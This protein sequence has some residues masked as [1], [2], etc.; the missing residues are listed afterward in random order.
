M[1][2]E[3]ELRQPDLINYIPKQAMVIYSTN[4]RQGSSE[5][6]KYYIEISDIMMDAQRSFL[7]AGK[8]VT[9]QSLQMLMDVVAETDKQTFHSVSDITP[10]NLLVIDQRA[11]RHILAWWRPAQRKTIMMQKRA[12]HTLWVPPMVFI[13]KNQGLSVAAMNK[14]K[15][16]GITTRL[17]H[18]PFF[19]VYNDMKVCLGTVKPP[20]TDGD[21]H[22]LIAEWEKAFWNS[23][24]TE[25]VSGAY[26]KTDLA[27]WWRKKR[28][29]RF[30]LKKLKISTINLRQLCQGN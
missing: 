28:R 5:N 11:G 4:P 30:N 27:S 21:I 8:P 18:A 2:I 15:R 10:A 25:T 17:H 7:S 19:N 24:F 26:K 23:E 20:N 6:V 3:N 12:S 16:P 22:Q 14:S 9:K 1:S 29:G 13:V